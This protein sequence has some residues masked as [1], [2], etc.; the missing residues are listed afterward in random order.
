MRRD[1]HPADLRGH[2]VDIVTIGQYLS[3]SCTWRWTAV[4]W[5]SS[6]HIGALVN[7][8]W[9][10][11]VG[12]HAHHCSYPA[13]EVHTMASNTLARIHPACHS[14]SPHGSLDRSEP[15]AEPRHTTPLQTSRDHHPQVGGRHPPE[16]RCG[17]DDRHSLVGSPSHD[18]PQGSAAAAR[19]VKRQPRP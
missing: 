16:N 15:R 3:G 4:T 12:K 14:T 18:G 6:R 5:S 19:P 1:R 2:Q 17:V 10:F 11:Y 7:R 9:A 8:S 13:G